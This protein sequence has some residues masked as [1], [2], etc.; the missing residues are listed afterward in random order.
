MMPHRTRDWYLSLA[1]AEPISLTEAGLTGGDTTIIR[2]GS[3]SIRQRCEED[4]MTS[5]LA[6]ILSGCAG[7]ALAAGCH[8]ELVRET[9]HPE[10]LADGYAGGAAGGGNRGMAGNGGVAGQVDQQALFT[11]GVPTYDDD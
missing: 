11:Q 3:H 6:A 8:D 9:V 5:R 4:D 2:V 7:I 10:I 1:A